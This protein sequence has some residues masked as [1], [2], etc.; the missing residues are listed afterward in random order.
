MNLRA[1]ILQLPEA[2]RLDYALQLIDYYLAPQ[3]E[4]YTWLDELGLSL[5]PQQGL[6]L[7]RL[8]R[9]GGQYVS[10][11]AL[12]AAAW[13]DR[14][15]DAWP[16]NNALRVHIHSLR[17][18]LERARLALA[19]DHAAGRGYRLRDLAARAQGAA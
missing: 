14:R 16:T 15:A 19:I 5:G 6:I 3:P 18:A 1:E 11:E 12:R 7:H 13:S 4:F 9:A 8:K 17:R 2:E 10:A